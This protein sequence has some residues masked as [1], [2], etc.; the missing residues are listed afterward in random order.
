MRVVCCGMGDKVMGTIRWGFS[1]S[2][3][4]PGV[5]TICTPS[6]KMDQNHSSGRESCYK[7]LFVPAWAGN[8]GTESLSPE[9]LDL[10]RI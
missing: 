7:K 4:K 5:L 3:K 2:L 9:N 1:K 8:R 10:M 6:E